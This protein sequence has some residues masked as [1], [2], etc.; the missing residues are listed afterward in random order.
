MPPFIVQ[1]QT[2]LGFYRFILLA[3]WCWICIA[4]VFAGLV[5][6][7]HST[8]NID[9]C[10]SV[11]A[12]GSV[13]GPWRYYSRVR[14]VSAL[15]TTLSSCHQLWAETMVIRMEGL[16]IAHFR[17]LIKFWHRGNRNLLDKGIIEI[18]NLLRIPHSN[19]PNRPDAL[20]TKHGWLTGRTADKWQEQCRQ[21][22]QA[23]CQV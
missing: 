9:C 10:L 11:S 7:L 13:S 6:A 18:Q 2:D 16:L 17:S 19:I 22:S 8:V 12:G 23:T 15:I 14:V 20:T 21:V 5:V 1:L 3:C 4:V